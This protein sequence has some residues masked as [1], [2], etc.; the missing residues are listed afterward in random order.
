MTSEP[1]PEFQSIAAAVAEVTGSLRGVRASLARLPAH[2]DEI[3]HLITAMEKLPKQLAGLEALVMRALAQVESICAASGKDGVAGA[4]GTGGAHRRP[5]R[6]PRRARGVAGDREGRVEVTPGVVTLRHARLVPPPTIPTRRSLLNQP[7]ESVVEAFREETP[8]MPEARLQ[9]KKS[10][11]DATSVTLIPSTMNADA[12]LGDSA[13][14]QV[15]ISTSAATPPASFWGTVAAD[16]VEYELVLR[17][18]S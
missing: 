15:V 3:P 4:D 18:R 1:F 14:S 8:T 12:M 11:I 2:V 13:I 10:A 16:G 9:L 6:D 5:G 17:R 7:D